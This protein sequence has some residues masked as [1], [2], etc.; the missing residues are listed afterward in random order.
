MRHHMPVYSTLKMEAGYFSALET[1]LP[2]YQTTLY[3]ISDIHR[4]YNFR[5]HIWVCCF[6]VVKG[7]SL[8]NTLNSQDGE[9][10]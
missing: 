10:S 7:A 9:N 5:S 3:H 6:V 2:V 4:H 1:L 8:Y